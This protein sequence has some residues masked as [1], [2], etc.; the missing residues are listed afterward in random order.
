MNPV[1]EGKPIDILMVED[2]DGDARLAREAMRDSKIK[3]TMH[4][5]R[6]GEE[7][8][9]FLH[10]EGK[11]TDAPRPDLVLLDLNLP[12]KNG[13]EVLAEMKAD[14][15]LKRIP[16]VILTV[17]SDE[18]DVRKTYDAH[19]NCYV[20]KPLDLNQFMK[21]VRSIEDFWLTIVKLPDG[22]S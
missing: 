20:T 19:A 3:N 8:M 12:R 11:Y 2:N 18:A 13:Q 14:M 7:A 15:D 16:V 1:M 17:S 5:V 4:H 22:T 10:K 21:V 6:D 9:A